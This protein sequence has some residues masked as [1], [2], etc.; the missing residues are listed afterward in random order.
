VLAGV[1][2]SIFIFFGM[3][4]LTNLFLA[5]GKGARIP[6]VVAGW[7]PNVIFGAIGLVLLYL[8]ATNRDLPRLFARRK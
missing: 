6:G 5:L 4:F 2:W 7:A 3:I 8:R 1:A